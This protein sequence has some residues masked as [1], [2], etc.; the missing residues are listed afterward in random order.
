M[1]SRLLRRPGLFSGAPPHAHFEEQR[2]TF[3]QDLEIF[4][5]CAQATQLR[6]AFDCM[7]QLLDKEYLFVFGPGP[8]LR[9]MFSRKLQ[10]G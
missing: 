10:P 1:N 3:V 9:T 2:R 4:L 6:R 8:A 7:P 5:M